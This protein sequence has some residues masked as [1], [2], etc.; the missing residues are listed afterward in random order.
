[1]KVQRLL[2]NLENV[3]CVNVTHKAF[4]KSVLNYQLERPT[5]QKN[6]KR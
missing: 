2:E 5:R 6:V 4:D 1:M 3:K